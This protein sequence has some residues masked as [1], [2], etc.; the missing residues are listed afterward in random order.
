[1]DTIAVAVIVMIGPTLV[2]LV[3]GFVTARARRDEWERQDRREDEVL[4]TAKALAEMTAETT[5][6]LIEKADAIH[7]L[8]NSDMTATRQE[9]LTQTVASLVLMK[10]LIRDDA[11]AGRPVS[12]EDLD[13]IAVTEARIAAQKLY[14]TERI[15]QQEAMDAR[16]PGVE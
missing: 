2:A 10:K 12:A 14:L 1:M 3:N 11:T 9:L 15:A 4:S 16:G 7:A 6:V 8:V 13:M 5:T